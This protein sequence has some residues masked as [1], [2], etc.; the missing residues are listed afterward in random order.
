M[1]KKKEVE[2]INKN[3]FISPIYIGFVP[4]EKSWKAECKRLDL[5]SVEYL[6]TLGKTYFFES[7]DGKTIAFVMIHEK[8]D[9]HPALAAAIICHEAVHVVEEVFREIGE[10][11]PSEEFRAYVTQNVFQSL[12]ESYLKHR[13]KK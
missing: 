5:G 6:K 9:K 13:G 8:C 3:L 4:D 2:Y 10:S 12:Y 7:K 1:P 11:K